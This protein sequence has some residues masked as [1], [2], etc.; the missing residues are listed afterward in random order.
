ML[1]NVWRFSLVFFCL[2]GAGL[3]TRTA[4]AQFNPNGFIRTDGWNFLGPLLNPFGAGP[5]LDTLNRNWVA[6]HDI[7]AENPRGNSGEMWD[8]IDFNGVSPATGFNLGGLAP[9]PTW[10]T[11]AFLEGAFGLPTGT[12]PRQDRV[13]YG[14]SAAAGSGILPIVNTQII[15]L[16]PGGTPIPIDNIMIVATT[17]VR[18]NGPTILADLCTGSDD[19]IQVFVNNGCVL[20]K[21][22]PRGYGGGC[23]EITPFVLP[24]GISKIAALVWEGGGGHNLGLGIQLAGSGVNLSDGNGIVDFLGPGTVEIGQTQY[25]VDREIPRRPLSCPLTTDQPLQVTLRG[26][27]PGADSDVITVTECVLAVDHPS[28]SISGVSNGGIVVDKAADPPRPL[29]P[30]GPDFDDHCEVG[31]HAGG[32]SDTTYDAGTGEYTSTSNSG[33]DLWDGANDF[34]FAYNRVSGDFDL[35]IKV[36]SRTHPTAPGNAVGNRWGKTGLLARLPQSTVSGQQEG[37]SKQTMIQDHYPDLQDAFRLAGRQVHNTCATMYEEVND[38]GPGLVSTAH[39]PYYRLTRRGNVIEGW[40]SD[41]VM[42]ESDPTNDTLWSARGRAD[43]WG[44]APEV[45]LG[46]GSSEHGDGGAGPLVYT[47]Q[48]LNYTATKVPIYTIAPI[49]RTITWTVTR[50]QL[51]A[52]LTYTV[53]YDVPAT[54]TFEGTASSGATPVGFAA[55]ATAA[56]L[57]T[58]S[59][60]VGMF[61]TAH[62]IGAPPSIGST[63]EAGGVYT[64][65]GSGSDIWD[66]GDH[67]QYAYKSVTGDFVATARVTNVVNPPNARWGRYGIMA[68]YTC[69]AAS[70]YSMACFTYRGE[71]VNN[72]DTHRH[73]SRRDHLNNGTTRDNQVLSALDMASIFAAPNQN[74]GWVRLTRRGDYFYTQFAPDNPGQPGQPGVFVVA[75]GDTHTG[76]PET[77]L[78][79]L[80]ASSHNTAGSNQLVVTYD[81]VSIGAP[82]PIENPCPD[83]RDVIVDKDFED[84]GAGLGGPDT[85]VNVGGLLTFTPAV[86]G[87]RLRLTQDGINDSASSVYFDTTGTN[88]GDIDFRADFDVFYSKADPAGLPADGLVFSVVNDSFANATGH[89]GDAGGGGGYNAGD[90]NLIPTDTRRRR[91]FAIEFDNWDGGHLD[92]DPPG[93]HGANAGSNAFYHVG[94]N[95]TNDMQSAQNNVERGVVLPPLFNNPDGIHVTVFYSPQNDAESH[96]RVLVNA[97]GGAGGDGVLA[98][99]AIGPRLVGDCYL[100]FTAATGGANANH[101]V[102]NLLVAE[103]TGNPPVGQFHR[104]DADGNGTLQLTDAVRILNVLFLGTGV[105]LCADSADADDNGTLQLTDAVRILN[106]LFLG[107]GVIPLPGPTAAP[108]GPDPTG[109]ALDCG[110]YLPCE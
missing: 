75:G 93:G 100:G 54:I 30:V 103:C 28:F 66:G 81:N 11:I 10:F 26:S 86:V 59:S 90:H 35:S 22:I 13:D 76:A 52:G 37:C 12:F 65:S 87:G 67:M 60:S 49:G 108:C 48:V 99:D 79:G 45:L 14:D 101:E 25:Y 42:V 5:S 46:F 17:Y 110:S 44:S 71:D 106:V 105:I 40:G 29:R 82:D 50:A 18:N 33:G 85:V 73:Q 102:D 32:A 3:A 15:P 107:T 84:G 41:D 89:V 63:V 61:D 64:V 96:I 7:G 51:N 92:N 21:S 91:G 62:D 80:V 109:D 4:E 39:P 72:Q 95:F 16:V 74:L 97:N 27:G 57:I 55:G 78:V 34:E 47:F 56:T 69:D 38:R 2:G 53:N 36:T 88:L 70:K 8:N 94:L 58:A 31:I 83:Q 43:D 23:Q 77:L 9:D 6:P 68:R 98:L 1:K 19:S 20:A 104:G 24:S